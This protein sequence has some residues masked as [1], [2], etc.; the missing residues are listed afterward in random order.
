MK[1]PEINI[2]FSKKKTIFANEAVTIT[3][4]IGEKNV[5]FCSYLCVVF[6]A[7]NDD[8]ELMN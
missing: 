8:I 1:I 4:K 6:L 7:M 2:G 5:F 3:R